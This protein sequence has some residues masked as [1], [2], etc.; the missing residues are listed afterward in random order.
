MS[1]GSP[2]TTFTLKISV[3][4]LGE[5]SFPKPYKVLLVSILTK[6]MFMLTTSPLYSKLISYQYFVTV[7]GISTASLF[8]SHH[9]QGNS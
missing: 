1:D 7:P 9:W 5:Q 8:V 6:V 3:G 2:H 4:V